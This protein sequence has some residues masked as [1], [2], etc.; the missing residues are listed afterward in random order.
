LR[1]F[2]CAGSWPLLLQNTAAFAGDEHIA[3]P[4][5]TFDDFRVGTVVETES[6][7]DRCWLSVAH[8]P[9]RRYH[10]RFEQQSRIGRTV[11]DIIGRDILDDRRRWADLYHF[12]CEGTV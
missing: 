12:A 8:D 9:D 7:G 10:A 11:D 2:R 1:S 5:I 3:G 6:D 4:H